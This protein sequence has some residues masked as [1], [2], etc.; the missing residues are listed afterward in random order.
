MVI[1]ETLMAIRSVVLLVD[2]WPVF[3]ESTATKQ[4]VQN[5]S[6]VLKILMIPKTRAVQGL[7]WNPC[8]WM[9][10]HIVL[11]HQAV[12]TIFAMQ[13]FKE[14]NMEILYQNA[15]GA[16]KENIQT[17]THYAK[18][19]SMVIR[20]TIRAPARTNACAMLATTNWTIRPIAPFVP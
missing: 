11:V 3:L 20:C 12:Q 8:A 6:C 17:K 2:V 1:V 15:L 14:E 16:P 5:V 19:A 13:G 7:L 4:V 18:F 9:C 10:L